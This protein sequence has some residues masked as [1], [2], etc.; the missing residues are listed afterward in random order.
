MRKVKLP[1]VKDKASE[2]LPGPPNWV[3]DL[4]GKVHSI[5]LVTNINLIQSLEMVNAG[6]EVQ[7]T[8]MVVIPL[9]VKGKVTSI[10]TI[11]TPNEVVS[12]LVNLVDVPTM[13]GEHFLLSSSLSEAVV[14]TV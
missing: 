8:S 2:G 13:A 9:L 3:D 7:G 14:D 1:S 11:I 10:S 4:Q 12:V 6:K 5:G